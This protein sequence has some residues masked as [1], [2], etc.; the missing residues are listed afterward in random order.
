[1]AVVVCSNC[2]AVVIADHCMVRQVIWDVG[3]AWQPIVSA[4]E[5]GSKAR[6]LQCCI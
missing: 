2:M 4:L 6:R 1:M 3:F 5:R